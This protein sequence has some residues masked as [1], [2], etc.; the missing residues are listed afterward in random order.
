MDFTEAYQ[1][2]CS[3]IGYAARTGNEVLLTRLIQTGSSV[4]IKDNRGWTPLHEAAA[5]DHLRCVQLLL[6]HLEAE[7]QCFKFAQ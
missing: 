4:D 1:D 7:G 3:S 6:P 5:H 2:R